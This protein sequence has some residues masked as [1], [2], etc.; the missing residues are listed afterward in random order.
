MIRKATEH[1]LRKSPWKQ[2]NEIC[3]KEKYWLP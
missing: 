1:L 3:L 2:K